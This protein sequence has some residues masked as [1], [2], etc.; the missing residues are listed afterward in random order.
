MSAAVDCAMVLHHARITQDEDAYN[1]GQMLHLHAVRLSQAE[2]AVPGARR[3]DGILG[4]IELLDICTQFRLSGTA[5]TPSSTIHTDALL[6]ILGAR[7]SKTMASKSA[8]NIVL[9]LT[10][11]VLMDAMSHRRALLLGQDEWVAALEPFCHSPMQKLVLLNLPVPEALECVDSLL[12]ADN[13]T[14]MQ[15]YDT[16]SSK[17]ASLNHATETWYNTIYLE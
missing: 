6:S 16:A 4:A 2:I 10:T 13:A 12:T 8:R 3:D 5:T 9:N 1:H 14:W 11:H 7:G 15:S 17:L